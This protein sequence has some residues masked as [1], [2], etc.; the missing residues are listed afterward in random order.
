MLTPPTRLA[1]GRKHGSVARLQVWTEFEVPRWMKRHNIDVYHGTH[2]AVPLL[3]RLP[4]VATVHDLA[5]VTAPL[6]FR[7]RLNKAYWR[8]LIESAKRATMIVVPSTPVADDLIRLLSRY[9]VIPA[10]GHTVASYERTMAAIDAALVPVAVTDPALTDE[11][12][13]KSRPA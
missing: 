1:A 12:S 6:L 3:G 9:G 8:L 7:G 13:P 4:R 10:I 5:P 2:F 11:V